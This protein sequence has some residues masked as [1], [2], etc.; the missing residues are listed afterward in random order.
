MRILGVSGSPRKGSTTE[1]LVREV[2]A[3]AECRTELPSSL[4]GVAGEQSTPTE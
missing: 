1:Q 4:P 3:G 2:L